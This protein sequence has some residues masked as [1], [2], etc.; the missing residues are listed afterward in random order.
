MAGDV[1]QLVQFSGAGLVPLAPD[2]GGA[3]VMNPRY[4]AAGPKSDPVCFV[5]NSVAKVMARLTFRRPTT[6]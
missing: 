5:Q 1:I 6:M 2:A 3:A 4:S